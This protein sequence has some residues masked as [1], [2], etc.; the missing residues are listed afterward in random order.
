MGVVG[1]TAPEV[2]EAM[3]D[4]LWHRGPDDAG[5]FFDNEVSLGHRRLAIVDLS[6]AGRQPLANEDGSVQV[7]FNGEIYNHHDF[8]RR[9]ETLGH[10][11]RTRTD[12]E[13][14]LHAYEEWGSDC[15]GQLDGMF[16][17]VLY[18]RRRRI[19]M[20]ARDRMGKKPL[21]YL[22][23][24]VGESENRIA[25]AFAS[26]IK[27][28]RAHPVIE[29]N[30]RLDH[31]ALVSYLLCDY[32]SRAERILSP[33]RLL[34]PAHAFEFGLPGSTR[35]G[36]RAWRYWESAPIGAAEEAAGEE[37]AAAR[38]IELLEA[39]IAR[40]LMADVPLGVFLSGGIDSS[41]LVA[42]LRRIRPDQP[43][44]T[45]SIG[46]DEPSFDE[47]AA[48]AMVARHFQ[49]RHHVRRFTITDM[50]SELPRVTRMLD[51]PFA[52]PSV[53]PVSMLSAFARECVTVA[54]GGD[55]GDELLAGYDP[56]RAIGPSRLYDLLTPARVHA[57]AVRWA[58]R[59]PRSYGNMGWPFRI[60]RFLRGAKLPFGYRLPTWM[61]AFSL[62][63]LERLLPDAGQELE[64]ARAYEEI[65]AE[66]ARMVARGAGLLGRASRFY[67]RFY[68]EGDILVKIDRASMLHSLEV[69]APFLDREVVEFCHGLPAAWKLRRGGK[70]LLRRAV[71]NLLPTA[72]LRR[73]KKGFGIPIAAWFRGALAK[74]G[75]QTLLDEWPGCLDFVC[76]EEVAR[77]WNEHQQGTANHYKELWALFMLARWAREHWDRS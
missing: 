69:R 70:Y 22:G 39:A 3:R 44:D 43:I 71:R 47:S 67:E 61:G 25:F 58:R 53:L 23:E 42:L 27:A 40:R 37:R 55:G 64:P 33:I 65:L 49:T 66:D 72:I 35:E 2:L 74:E 16:A 68:L 62:P 26:E 9:L 24:A 32:V 29:A 34:P 28:L 50:L 36:F 15:V 76:R 6:P 30:L 1:R 54:L 8:R 20:G 13:S 48:A 17:F 7:V 56:F 60:E 21:Y 5:T 12:T 4:R 77:L 75:R 41:T 10:P 51:E 45:F 73:S 31:R 46:F 11:F 18:D 59:L 38:L 14:I 52:D 19:L 57:Q 63:G